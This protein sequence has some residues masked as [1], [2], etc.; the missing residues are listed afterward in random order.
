MAASRFDEFVARLALLLN[1]THS[2]YEGWPMETFKTKL[3]V[4]LPESKTMSAETL[5]VTS[6]AGHP[7]LF[8]LDNVPVFAYGL[9]L[10]DIVRAEKREDDRWHFLEVAKPSGLL[11]VRVAGLKADASRFE[12]LL[13]LLKPVSIASES[14][15]ERYIA[16]AVKPESFEKIDKALEELEQPNILIVEIA[17]D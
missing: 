1:E 5:W 3:V 7:G 15:G 4:A 6:E 16:Y 14:Y 12:A 10:D 2:P 8:K 11:T 17:N 13:N 9:A